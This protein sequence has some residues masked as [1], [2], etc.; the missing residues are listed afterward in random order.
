MLYKPVTKN[1]SVGYHQ[2]QIL[3]PKGEGSSLMPAG[4]AKRRTE[5]MQ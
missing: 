2:G 3:D 5:W 1:P 4:F